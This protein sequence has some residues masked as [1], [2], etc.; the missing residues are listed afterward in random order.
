MG[1]GF[2]RCPVRIPHLKR[3]TKLPLRPGPCRLSLY[4]SPDAGFNKALGPKETGSTVTTA[5]LV[6][7]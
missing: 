6:G 2:E 5:E 4:L 7:P 1:T 3:A